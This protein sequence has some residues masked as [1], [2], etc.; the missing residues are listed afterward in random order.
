MIGSYYADS[1]AAAVCCFLQRRAMRIECGRSARMVEHL[2]G[3]VMQEPQG[4]QACP[5]GLPD[6]GRMGPSLGRYRCRRTPPLRLT[7]ALM[8]KSKAPSSKSRMLCHRCR[9]D[10]MN[11]APRRSVQHGPSAS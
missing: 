3:D 6:R 8:E 4:R 7:A 11:P 2:P 5:S 10:P 9:H 1:I